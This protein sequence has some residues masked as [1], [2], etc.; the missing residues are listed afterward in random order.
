MIK[1]NIHV[2][3]LKSFSLLIVCL[4]ACKNQDDLTMQSI[5]ENEKQSRTF[6]YDEYGRA[7]NDY[8]YYVH[9][10]GKKNP[11]ERFEYGKS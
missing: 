3:V 2:V 4:I 7:H 9:K 10:T 8:L 1:K 5:S 11:R 6:N